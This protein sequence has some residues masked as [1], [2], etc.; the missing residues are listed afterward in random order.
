MYFLVQ[1]FD[2][3]RIW[4]EFDDDVVRFPCVNFLNKSGI[5]CFS[6]FSKFQPSLLW[7]K[8]KTLLSL[9]VG[10]KVQKYVKKKRY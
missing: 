3:K 2:L 9:G 1:E 6:L 4:K 5:L 8:K 10:C 7:F